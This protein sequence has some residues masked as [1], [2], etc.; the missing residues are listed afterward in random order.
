MKKL[1]ELIHIILFIIRKDKNENPN[2]FNFEEERPFNIRKL[3]LRELIYEFPDE[4]IWKFIDLGKIY[5]IIFQ[6]TRAYYH[7]YKKKLRERAT[8]STSREEK[9]ENDIMLGVL[10]II[11]S[12]I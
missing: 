4:E 11:K 5:N 1:D 10:T 6:Q 3:L 12:K 7:D 8:K 9:I 2:Y